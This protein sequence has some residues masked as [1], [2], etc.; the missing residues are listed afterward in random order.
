MAEQHYGP[1]NA[2]A[3]LN[4]VLAAMAALGEAAQGMVRNQ[5]HAEIAAGKGI[6]GASGDPLAAAQHAAAVQ[7]DAAQEAAL[8]ARQIGKG[9][10]SAGAAWD[11]LQAALSVPPHQPQS[12][13]SPATAVAEAAGSTAP[14]PRLA[15]A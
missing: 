3:C 1:H 7:Q 4:R 14:G 8:A 15:L 9:L 12:K 6:V 2:A 11:A 10:Q 13:P 5:H